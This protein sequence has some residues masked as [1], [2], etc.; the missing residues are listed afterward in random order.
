[1]TALLKFFSSLYDKCFPKKKIKLKPQQYNIL[2]ITKGIKKLPRRK[3][4]SYKKFLEK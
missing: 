4:K 2:W 1:M 3:Q